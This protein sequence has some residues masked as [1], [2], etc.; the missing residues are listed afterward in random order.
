MPIHHAVLALLARNPSHGY[1]LKAAFEEAIGPQWGELNIGHLYQVLDRLVRDGLVT[2]RTVPQSNRP[3]RIDYRLTD[4][5]RAELDRWLETPF[6]RSGGYRDDFFLK[7]LAASRLGREELER[8]LRVQREAY[9]NELAALGE[10]RQRH[11]AEPLVAL[12]VEAACAHTA[13]NLR[14]VDQAEEIADALARAGGA[15]AGRADAAVEPDSRS[16]SA[17]A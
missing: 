3:D 7:L 14:I 5:G 17:Q 9:I 13:A 15:S 1:E 2:R 16:S 6:V 10:I 11:K 8:V 12:L 4:A